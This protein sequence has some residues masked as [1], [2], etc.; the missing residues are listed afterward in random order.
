MKI[1]QLPTEIA[2]QVNLTAQGLKKIGHYSINAGRVNKFNY[3]LDYDLQIFKSGPFKQYRN[4]F[5]FFKWADEFDI[6]HYHKS[7][8]WP[9]GLDLE[10]L[11]HKKKRFFVEFWGSDIRINELESQRNPFF[12]QL[13]LPNSKKPI[14]RL[15]FWSDKTQEVIISDNSM[16]IFLKPYFKKIHVVRQRLDTSKYKPKYPSLE[17]KIPKIVHAPSKQKIKGTIF[18]EKAIENLKKK[19][20]KFE[21]IRVENMNHRE[22]MNIY[23]DADIIVDQLILG[24]Y[25]IFACEGMALGK[26]VIC[27]IQDTLIDTYP[28][29][30]PIVNAN[31]NTIENEL[32]KLILSSKTRHVK[33]KASREYVQAVHDIEVVAKRLVKIYRGETV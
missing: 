14:K 10:Y 29:T 4:P 32:E 25:G 6:F 8:L 30:L 11:N 2:G 16:D 1:L 19:N 20:L 27:Y 9:F 31:P 23:T 24:S 13:K 21:Y 28:K 3:P 12:E 15:K 26:P 33:G 17:N 7:Y 5:P 18:V 22:A